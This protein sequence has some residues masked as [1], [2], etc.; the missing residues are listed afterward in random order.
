M[1]LSDL[2][3]ILKFKKKNKMEAIISGG[4]AQ[5][6]YESFLATFNVINKDTPGLVSM[7]DP[8]REQHSFVC[9]KLN[10]H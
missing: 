9:I 3:W 6:N 1:N 2:S 4:G 8:L 10:S 7:P 5:E